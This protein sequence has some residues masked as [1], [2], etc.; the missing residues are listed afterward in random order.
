M[1]AAIV[2][3]RD[4]NQSMVVNTHNTEKSVLPS[5]II[6]AVVKK[7]EEKSEDASKKDSNEQ[8]NPKKPPP[9]FDP[10]KA[11]AFNSVRIVSMTSFIVSG[12]AAISRLS[13]MSMLPI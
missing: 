6:Q 4:L 7:S 1:N 5:P 10:N 2:G 3:F 12:I 11:T 9:L 13:K 8:S